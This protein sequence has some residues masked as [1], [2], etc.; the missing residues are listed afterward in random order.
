MLAGGAGGRETADVSEGPLVVL[1]G[2]FDPPH[3]GHLV[4]AECARWQVGATRVLFVPA[5]DPY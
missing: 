5:G 3:V 1:G 2:T 4:L